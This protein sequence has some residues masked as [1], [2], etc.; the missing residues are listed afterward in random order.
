VLDQEIEVVLAKLQGGGTESDPREVLRAFAEKIRDGVPTVERIVEQKV[1]A[2]CGDEGALCFSCKVQG[3]IGEQAMMAA[4]LILPQLMPLAKEALEAI[5]RRRARAKAKKESEA[6][7][8]PP[9]WP[10]PPPPGKQAF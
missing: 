10:P 1:C 3:V 9:T 8:P 5:G 7:G 2:G 4:P 6:K